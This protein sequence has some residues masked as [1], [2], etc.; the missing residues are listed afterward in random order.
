MRAAGDTIPVQYYVW[1]SDSAE[2]AAYLPTVRAMIEG[3]GE[4]FVV[5]VA[6]N[7]PD[8]VVIGSIEYAV[9]H[10]GSP[11]VLVLGHEHCGAVAAAAVRRGWRR[12]GVW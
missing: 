8:P 1:P 5:R 12:A 7:V 9:A 2:C 4:I 11:L 6:G 3:L 10:L